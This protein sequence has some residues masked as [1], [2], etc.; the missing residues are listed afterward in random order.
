MNMSGPW[1]IPKT[2]R[3]C[4]ASSS[5][6]GAGLSRTT[7]WTRLAEPSAAS[8]LFNRSTAFTTLPARSGPDGS[9]RDQSSSFTVSCASARVDTTIGAAE[10]PA[11]TTAVSSATFPVFQWSIVA[12]PPSCDAFH[13][14]VVPCYC[15]SVRRDYEGLR[16]NDPARTGRANGQNRAGRR[17]RPFRAHTTGTRSHMPFSLIAREAGR[18]QICGHR[19]YSLYYPENTLPA[20]RAA[21]SWGATM[22]EID[23]VL[24]A[25]G[26]PIILHD[27]TVDQTTDGHGFAAD[28]SLERIRVSMRDPGFISALPGHGS[29]HLSKCLTGRT[30]RDE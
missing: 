30:A 3:S 11:N 19:G 9:W 25:D 27:L 28:L 5:K 24:T 29:R 20:F 10:Q 7:T 14:A 12:F 6:P 15:T 22:V 23:V 17:R 13:R 21:K 16:S 4:N 1:P 18:V 26:E 8:S 2:L